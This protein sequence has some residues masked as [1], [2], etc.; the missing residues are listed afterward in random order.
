MNEFDKAEVSGVVAG[1]V[2]TTDMDRCVTGIYQRVKVNAESLVALRYAKDF[3]AIAMI[4]RS[5][6][7]LAVDMKLIEVIP[8]AE[9][10][11]AAFSEAEKLRAAKMIVAYKSAHPKASIDSDVHALFIKNNEAR[12]EADNRKILGAKPKAKV[13]HW[14]GYGSLKDRVAFLKEP[15]FEEIYE[16]KYPQLSWYTHA[17]GMTGFTLQASSYEKLATTH[18]YLALQLYKLVLRAIIDKYQFTK[19]DSKILAKMKQ[20]ELLPMIPA[21][22]FKN[23]YENGGSYGRKQRT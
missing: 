9:I 12:I 4:T 23:V 21:G 17:A 22:R 8:D 18:H 6:F 15:F 2:A 19:W 3:Q 1:L 7:E 20:A 11:I 13:M 14:S 10:R 5:L 16:V